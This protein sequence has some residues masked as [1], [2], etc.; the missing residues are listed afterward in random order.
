MT[1]L[2]ENMADMLNI[3]VDVETPSKSSGPK[4]TDD[5][6]TKDYEYTR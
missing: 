1:S 2:E 5:D 4:T 3:S 6:Q